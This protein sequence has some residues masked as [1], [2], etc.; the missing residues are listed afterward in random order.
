MRTQIGFN[1]NKWIEFALTPFF[2]SGTT[3]PVLKTVTSVTSP[4]RADLSD[5]MANYK[6]V[7]TKP[8]Y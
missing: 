1:K 7:Y 5:T 2:M 4:L 6:I 3:E 8:A